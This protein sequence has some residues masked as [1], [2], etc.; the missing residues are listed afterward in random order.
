MKT[1][2]IRHAHAVDSRDGGA[3]ADED[4]WLTDKGRMV[5]RKVGDRLRDE[6]YAAD[7]IVTSPLVRAVQTA[8][9]VARGLKYKGVVEVFADLA[10]DGSIGAAA[11]ALEEKGGL[12][13]AVGHEPGISALASHLAGRPVASFRKGEAVLVRDGKVDYRLD[14]ESL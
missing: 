3:G 13:V 1:L 5:A 6:G 7:A 10:P 14:P 4:R 9:L 11:Q 8:E 12:V 2:L